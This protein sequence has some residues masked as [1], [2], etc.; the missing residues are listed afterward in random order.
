MLKEKSSEQEDTGWPALPVVKWVMGW[1]GEDTR[2]LSAAFTDVSIRAKDA[3][4]HTARLI[5][6][7]FQLESFVKELPIHMGMYWQCIIAE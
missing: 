7:Y 5:K 1:D 4:G 6:S 2:L 3:S